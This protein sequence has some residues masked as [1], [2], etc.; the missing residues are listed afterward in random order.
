MQEYKQRFIEFML[1]CGVLTFGDFT[2]KSG[3]KTPYFINTG[4]YRLGSQMSRLG[5]FYAQAIMENFPERLDILFGPAYKGI[6]LVT[7]AAI[8]LHEQHGRETGICF[9]RKETKD[10]GEGGSL[11]GAKPKDGQRVLIVEDVTTAGTSIYE[12]VPLIKAAAQVELAGLIISVDRQ[13]KG[14]S[15]KGALAELRENFGFKTAAIVTIAEVVEYLAGRAIGGKIL[16]DDEIMARIR[17]YR[18]QY[19]A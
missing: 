16:L 3:R 4:N 7:A 19:G 11:V 6:P 9:N 13:E 2:T 5:G 15:G 17:D 14:Q 1:D 12:T 18:A 8:A 10:H